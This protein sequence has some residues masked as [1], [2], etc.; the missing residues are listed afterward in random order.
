[1]DYDVDAIVIG[2]GPAGATTALLLARSGWRVALIEKKNFPRA[3]VCGEFISA[4]SLPLMGELGIMD[5]YQ[6]NAGPEVSR[7]GWF[8][9]EKMLM[10]AMPSVD[11]SMSKW[12][13]ALGREHLDTALLQEAKQAGV[14]VWQPWTV[15][16][17][18]DKETHFICTMAAKEETA[19]I[20]ARVAVMAQ[21]S[22][23]R[24]FIQRLDIMHKNSDLLAFKTHFRASELDS[25]LMTLISFPGGYGGL[26]HSDANRVTLSCC[27]RRDVL[28]KVRLQNPGLQAGDAVLNY[29]MLTCAGARQVLA[30]A[31]RDESWLSVGPIRPGIRKCY[32]NGIFYVGNI[33]GEAHP[34]IAEGISMA[35]QSGWLLASSLVKQ[36]SL[37]RN[38]LA[39]V[40]YEYT[41][42]WRKQF[43]N[44]IH[45][46]AFFAQITTR[47]KGMAVLLPIVE[48]FPGLLTLGAN[49]S[50]KAKELLP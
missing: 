33:A 9:A 43:A 7:V 37:S 8:G 34:I 14:L 19:V 17:L 45:A 21:G 5:F 32:E 35:M 49:L 40:G 12:G 18:M 16:H 29:I 22:W 27:I 26:V 36:P 31:Q 30:S 10:A 48:R 2:G 41:K 38:D 1:M 50:G 11:K 23:E 20:K 24:P 47:P 4:T 39:S 46:A 28:Q 6:K 3:K 25:D 13:R 15:R 42:K 44:R